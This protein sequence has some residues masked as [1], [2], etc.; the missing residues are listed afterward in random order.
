MGRGSA[1]GPLAQLPAQNAA[2]KASRKK[3]GMWGG[4][5]WVKRMGLGFYCSYCDTALKCGLLGEQHMTHVY[6]VTSSRSP[7]KS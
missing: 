7:V 3:A 1:E 5:R 6:L 2:G 4:L